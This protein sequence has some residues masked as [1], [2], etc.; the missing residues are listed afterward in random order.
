M[1]RPQETAYL[2]LKHYL[3]R[4]TNPR[5]NLATFVSTYME[6]EAKRLIVDSL[7]KNFVDPR[8]YPRTAD[9]ERRCVSILANLYHLPSSNDEVVVGTST[10][11]SSEAIM[12]AL[13]AMKAKWVERQQAAGKDGRAKPNLIMSSVVQV[14][15]QKAARYFDVDIQY[16]NCSEDRFVLDPTMA[17]GLVNEQ[18][19]GICCIL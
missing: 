9:I 12:L 7:S 2:L 18:T 1:A 17:V 5:F 6:P 16:V 11:G 13:L 3:S 8:A 14:C 4:D 10:L 15:W 19:I